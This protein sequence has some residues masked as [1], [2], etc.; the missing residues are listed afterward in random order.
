MS[1]LMKYLYEFVQEHH[2]GSLHED[3]EYR[4]YTRSIE[5]QRERVE[6]YLDKE[7]RRE[8]ESLINDV[9]CRDSIENEHTF[10]AALRL[11]GELIALVRA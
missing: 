5:S 6:A 4:E 7:Q 8:L 1:N 3:E 11:A 10:Q 9:I 2:M